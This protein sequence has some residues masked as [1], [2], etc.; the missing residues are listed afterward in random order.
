[1]ILFASVSLT[2]SDGSCGGCDESTV[3]VFGLANEILGSVVGD[4]ILE[5]TTDGK[6]KSGR[7]S[8]RN[9]PCQ[10]LKIRKVSI[11]VMGS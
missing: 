2:S 1:V 4:A 6:R 7:G 8:D 9:F 11:V 3:A 5:R 10:T